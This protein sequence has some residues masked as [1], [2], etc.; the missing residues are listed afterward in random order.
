[1]KLNE[2]T[3]RFTTR[4]PH[5]RDRSRQKPIEQDPKVRILEKER[6]STEGTNYYGKHY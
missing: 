6:L 5:T 4:N 3:K 2:H 1:M